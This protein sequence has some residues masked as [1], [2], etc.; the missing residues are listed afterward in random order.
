MYKFLTKNG[1][2]VAFGV[3]VLVTLAF[4]ISA[5]TGLKADG[6]DAGTDLTTMK[7]K[8]EG[9]GYFNIGLYLTLFLLAV[10]VIALLLFMVVDVFKFPKQTLK[11]IIG[12]VALIVI[13]F[14]IKAVAKVEVGPLW[15]RLSEDFSVTDG[16][17]KTISAGIW[18]TIL[19]LA[20]ATLTMI[21]SELRN[22]FK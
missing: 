14:I 7:D 22:F 21:L 16:I 19:L 5:I 6:Y 8:F 18:I 20:G 11:G 10:C 3:G 4:I 17:S 13:F 15:S 9:M 12:F 1:T 2:F